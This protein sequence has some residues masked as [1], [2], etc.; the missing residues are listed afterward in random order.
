MSKICQ[1]LHNVLYNVYFF[2][3]QDLT[4]IMH[5]IFLS[6]LFGLLY[7][8]RIKGYSFFFFLLNIVYLQCCIS[9]MC[10]SK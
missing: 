10:I 7:F 4:K 8:N 1:L 9:F 6:C 3:V 2:L 5:C